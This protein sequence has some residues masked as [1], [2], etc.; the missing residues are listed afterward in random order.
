MPD[1]LRR[2]RLCALIAMLVLS[3]PPARAAT[4]LLSATPS[5]APSSSP[6]AA[7]RIAPA[8]ACVGELQQGAALSLV[9]GKSLLL[10]LQQGGLPSPAWLR[11]VGDADVVQL[12]PMA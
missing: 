8:P 4:T 9:Q 7:P 1:R 3:M 12:E 2:R 10:D 6:P 5:S 11:A